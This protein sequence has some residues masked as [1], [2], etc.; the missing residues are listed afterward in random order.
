MRG[1]AVVDAKAI[2]QDERLCEAAAAQSDVG[3]RASCSA[4]FQKN[5]GI[6]AQWI[7]RRGDKRCELLKWQNFSTGLGDSANGTGTAEPRTT[8]VSAGCG[9]PGI[10]EQIAA[11]R[12]HSRRLLAAERKR[13]ETSSIKHFD[14]RLFVMVSARRQK[15]KDDL[16]L[17]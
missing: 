17:L 10:R 7:E 16:M 12:L 13:D 5:R 14:I 9:R 11:R 1:L 6:V 2:E 8:M 4:L 15:S 3:L